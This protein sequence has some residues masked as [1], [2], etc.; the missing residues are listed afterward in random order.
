MSSKIE[1]AKHL[2][3]ELGGT[4]RT[5]Q[6]LAAG[7][8]PRTLY[9]LRDSGDLEQLSWGLYRLT[10][11]PELSEPDLAT[12]AKR[13]PDGVICLISALA[14]H[15]LTTQVPH[16]VHLALE[17]GTRYPKLDHPPLRVYLFS[18]A[19]FLSGIEEKMYD[20][21]KVH[22][23]NAEKTLADCFKFR[24]K[25]GLD[26]ATEALRIYRR[27]PGANLQHVYEYARI[28]RVA[29]VIRPYLEAGL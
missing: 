23:Y 5:S 1:E 28:C 3:K 7:I 29:N 12:V 2:I 11:L 21:V 19:A 20:E 27:R 15:E 26:V 6:A 4:V 24:Y 25:I 17:R 18:K 13:V 16:A 8:H 22:V 10:G 9:A 14:I